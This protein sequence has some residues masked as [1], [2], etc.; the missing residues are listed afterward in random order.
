MRRLLKVRSATAWLAFLLRISPATTFSF[1]GLMRTLRST[2]WAW[3]SSSVRGCFGLLISAPLG[4]LVGGMAVEGPRRRELAELMADHVLV[5]LHRQELVPVVDAEGQADELR[6]GR[7]AAR[8]DA[9]DLV[10]ARI[11]RRLGLV[12]QV[13]V[14]ERALPYGTRH[15]SASPSDGGG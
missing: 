9:D 1:C 4:L 14:D 12:E 2:A 13:P 5:D 8:P 3:V 15:L 11:A 7:E 10:A 6:Q